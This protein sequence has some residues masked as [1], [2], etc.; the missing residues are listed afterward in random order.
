MLLY[1]NLSKIVSHWQSKYSYD[2]DSPIQWDFAVEFC[3][4][5][6][7]IICIAKSIY[8]SNHILY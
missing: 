4:M 5:P 7:F 2:K 8:P 1:P 6:L 3:S